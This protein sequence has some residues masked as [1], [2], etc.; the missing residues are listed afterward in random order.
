MNL[1][2]N[3]FNRIEISGYSALTS[4]LGRIERLRELISRLSDKA[5]D[6]TEFTGEACLVN[7]SEQQSS[8]N[9][10]RWAYF[11]QVFISIT[12]WMIL[13]FAAGFLIGLINPK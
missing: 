11:S 9:M 7:S 12:I 13:G 3:V 8:N 4:L 2:S 5:Q 6:P 10:T 1:N